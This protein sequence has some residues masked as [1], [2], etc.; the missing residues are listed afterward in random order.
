[1]EFLKCQDVPWKGPEKRTK[2]NVGTT[3]Q[4]IPTPAVRFHA[5][6]RQPTY[7]RR[8]SVW[9]KYSWGSR[10]GGSRSNTLKVPISGDH[11]HRMNSTVKQLRYRHG[12]PLKPERRPDTRERRKSSLSRR[13]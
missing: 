11:K 12:L 3:T 6:S 4:N 13:L 2:L 8:V 10:I 1:M 9:G 5:G 7:M